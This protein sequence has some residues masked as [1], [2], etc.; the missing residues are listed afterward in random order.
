MEPQNT[1][2][3]LPTRDAGTTETRQTTKTPTRRTKQRK[4][5]AK[6][7]TDRQLGPNT[8][9]FEAQHPKAHGIVSKKSEQSPNI[10]EHAPSSL[11]P[12]WSKTEP[13][14]A[15][16]GAKCGVRAQWG[17]NPPLRYFEAMRSFL[18]WALC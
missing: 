10:A 2:R 17:P 3:G 7:P 6:G 16:S 11:E 15:L 4:G 18:W 13:P 9:Q 14:F 1:K 5:Q 8:Q 12:P